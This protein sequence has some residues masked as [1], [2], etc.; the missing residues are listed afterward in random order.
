MRERTMPDMA[1]ERTGDAGNGGDQPEF[2]HFSLLEKELRTR[3]TQDV[4]AGFI[5]GD[6][7]HE[8][9]YGPL[10][11]TNAAGHSMGNALHAEL[12]DPRT[13]GFLWSVAFISVG[14]LL[15]LKQDFLDYADRGGTGTILTSTFQWFNSPDVF[16]ELDKLTKDTHG[17]VR[18][19]IWNGTA[20]GRLAWNR[21]FHAKGYVFSGTGEE[22]VY[23][24]SSNFTQSALET[25]RE[26]NLRVTS[27]D[28]GQI[29]SQIEAEIH[30]QTAQSVPLSQQWIDEYKPLWKS[31]H[32]PMDRKRTE[33]GV[34]FPDEQDEGTDIG[35][36]AAGDL[37]GSDVRTDVDGYPGGFDGLNPT[38]PAVSRIEPNDM[39]KV[40]LRALARTREEGHHRGIIVSA[41]GTGKT[42]LSALDA[43]SVREDQGEG[44]SFRLLYIVGQR[45]I[46][47]AAMRSYQRVFGC[48]FSQM[49]L[50]SGSDEGLPHGARFFRGG[51]ITELLA[52]PSVRFVFTTTDTIGRCV[53]QIDPR[54]FTYVVADEAH[55]STAKTYK[56]VISRLRPKFLLGMTA[57]PERTGEGS[58]EVFALFDHN[59]VYEIRLRGALDAGLL[60]PFHYYGVAEYAGRDV[61][62]DARDMT[63]EQQTRIA[64]ELGHPSPERARYIIN[65]LALYAPA[66]VPVRG[67]VFCSRNEEAQ[68]L[69]DLFNQ[70]DDPVSGRRW[71]TRAVTSS[72]GEDRD[73]AVRDLEAGRLDY[74]FTV[75]LF[76][77]GVDIPSLNQIVMLRQTKSSIVFTQQLGR[78]LRRAPHKNSVVVIDF[79]GN[80]TT[81]YLIP[82]ALYGTTADNDVLRRQL[83][84]RTIGFS[85]I[86]FDRISRERVLRTVEAARLGSLTEL[87]NEYRRLRGEHG[88]VPTLLEVAGSD[89]STAVQM[90]TV[91][92]QH[93]D[94]PA[95]V[96]SRETKTLRSVQDGMGQSGVTGLSASDRFIS[97]LDREFA[98]IDEKDPSAR[99]VL[100]FAT[101]LARGL[102]PHELLAL[103]EL[104][105]VPLDPIPDVEDFRARALGLYSGDRQYPAVEL[106]AGDLDRYVRIFL[107][108][109]GTDDPLLC[110]AA[111]T[112]AHALHVLGVTGY[113]TATNQKLYGGVP[114]IVTGD[115]VRANPTVLGWFEHYPL[116]HAA[117]EDAIRLGLLSCLRRFTEACHEHRRIER[118]FVYSEKYGLYDVMRL[119][120]WDKEIPPLNVGGYKLDENNTMPILIKY[121]D[122][123]YEDRFIDQKSLTYFSKDRRTL[124][125]KEIMWLRRHFD[126]A[127]DSPG[128]AFVPVFVMRRPAEGEKTTG[129]ADTNYYY[130][131]HVLRVTEMR[132]AH[133]HA[134]PNEKDREQG[135]TPGE[136]NVV[137][138]RLDLADSL[139]SGLF[140]HLT[141]RTLAF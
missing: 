96:L 116:L 106:H 43:R 33:S 130:V 94:Y 82:L 129:P 123:Q 95:F 41:T 127:V 40:A 134:Q 97:D 73:Q 19:L 112:S 16:A 35:S 119:C 1:A 60:C 34:G 20:G 66:G 84:R 64:Q 135:R 77:E 133:H 48:P 103:A 28:Q 27:T 50:L 99:G 104:Y 61:R 37:P 75:D 137:R 108:D 31:N 139:G 30:S 117:F 83:E 21:P 10:L 76:N 29:V 125:S 89:L 51:Q 140:R 17:A 15:D 2:S 141:G 85:S 70:M 45:Q 121:A 23:V 72:N 101:S 120:C 62:V 38:S 138:M 59:V 100:R 3:I 6:Q 47:L 105:H 14:E 126:P 44:S 26:W 22:T 91:E 53:G 65:K 56:A 69:S 55:H 122:S 136:V 13:S 88:H 49:A 92:T 90:A 5:D 8:G 128:T 68:R 115:G 4:L 9:D 74:L 131:G 86:S 32:Q 80:Y 98:R 57:T 63:A 107:R 114:L 78:G 25:N 113:F 93:H 12:A 124:S 109:E 46:L 110:F 118:G 36:D 111:G 7:A 87:T 39:Q 11:I 58:D 132:Q 67:L 18:T 54:A 24:G 71:R 42:Y 102:R 81:N 79:I 52:D